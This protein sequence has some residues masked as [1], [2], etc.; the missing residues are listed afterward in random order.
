MKFCEMCEDQIINEFSSFIQFA[1][2][3]KEHCHFMAIY[4]SDLLA[5]DIIK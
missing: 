4:S 2:E 3:Y 1:F 5:F